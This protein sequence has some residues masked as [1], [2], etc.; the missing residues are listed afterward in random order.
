MKRQTLL[1]ASLAIGSTVWAQAPQEAET[2]ADAGEHG[3]ARV[4][5]VNGNANTARGDSGELSPTTVNEPLVTGDRVIT[6]NGRAELQF[7]GANFLRLAQGAEVRMGDLSYRRYLVQIAQG[8][9]TFRVLRDSDAQVEISLPNSSVR[10]RRQGIYRVLVRPDGTAEVTIRSGEMEVLSQ[11]GSEVLQAGVTLLSRGPIDNPEFMT[12]AAIANDEWDRWNSDR[13]RAFERYPEVSRYASPDVYGT[14]ELNNYG[15]WVNDASYG[16][17]WVPTVSA[18]WAPYSN[19]RWVWVDYY[20]WS[21]V[22]Y[23]SWGWAPFHYGRWYRGPWGWAWYPGGFGSRHYWSPALVGFVGWGSPGFGSSISVGFGN[24]GWVPLA[25]REPYRPWYG[26]GYGGSRAVPYANVNVINIYQNARFNG[27]TGVNAGEFGHGGGRMFRPSP[28]D[29]ARGG[30]PVSAPM[31]DRP[32]PNGNRIYNGNNAQFNQSPASPSGNGRREGRFET[33][34]T[35]ANSSANAN[36]G[37]PSAGWRRFDGTTPDGQ[38]VRISPPIVNNRGDNSGNPNPNI[39]NNGAPDARGGNFG[40]FG[41]PRRGER[42]PRVSRAPSR[43]EESQPQP[44]YSPPPP[45]T[46]PS[47]GFGGGGVGGRPAPDQGRGP[48]REQGGGG[49][50]RENRGHD[51][52]R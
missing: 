51:G 49:P 8:L 4:S 3:V 48:R 28:V 31:V 50:A 42:D 20:G 47:S 17:V 1:I 37:R 46:Q 38:A 21:W 22:S 13:D 35:P 7:D 36:P 5:L 24:I 29:I 14:E 9:V 12:V 16:N 39:N 26:R 23:D 45:Q 10:P 6:G 44:R 18:D 27:V 2:P 15:R 40:N 33:Q 11:G 41:G 19:G 52:R 34:Q 32:R 25:P 30:T 43:Q